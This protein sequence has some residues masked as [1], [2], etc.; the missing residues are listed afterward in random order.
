MLP[1]RAMKILKST[2]RAP[3]FCS[4]SRRINVIILFLM[5]INATKK[6]GKKTSCMV[7]F[8]VSMALKQHRS[9]FSNSDLLTFVVG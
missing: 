9:Y 6:T 5:P 8:I 3:D 1:V 7:D 4:F 2:D